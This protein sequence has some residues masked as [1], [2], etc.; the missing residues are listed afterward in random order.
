[1]TFLILAL[2]IVSPPNPMLGPNNDWAPLKAE[3]QYCTDTATSYFD[4]TVCTMSAYERAVH[5]TYSA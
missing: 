5:P 4:Y 3:Y 2:A 1:M